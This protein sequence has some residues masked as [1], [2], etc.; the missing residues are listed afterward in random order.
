MISF[1]FLI[2]YRT[3]LELFH[4]FLLRGTS[5][6]VYGAELAYV[7]SQHL[8][9]QGA[10]RYWNCVLDQVTRIDCLRFTFTKFTLNYS[11]DIV[12]S[13]IL[14]R[15][16]HS[17]CESHTPQVISGP[18]VDMLF[19]FKATFI[20]SVHHNC[21]GKDCRRNRCFCVERIQSVAKQRPREVER[22]FIPMTEPDVR[23]FCYNSSFHWW[24]ETVSQ[25]PY[26]R[27]IW[28]RVLTARRRC[29]RV[30]ADQMERIQI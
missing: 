9:R 25:L 11:S 18:D 1:A 10:E 14:T 5:R 20:Y 27:S 21:R 26:H 24:C 7:V 22:P 8:P 13:M 15:K 19:T 12:F 2:S 4:A 28:E 6:D 3:T 17:K 16:L 29:S 23:W 30:A